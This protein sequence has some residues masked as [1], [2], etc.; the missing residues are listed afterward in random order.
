MQLKLENY[1]LT[2]QI[3]TLEQQLEKIALKKR[4]HSDQLKIKRK[5]L[6]TFQLQLAELEL[7]LRE[8]DDLLNDTQR[9][10]VATQYDSDSKD[11]ELLFMQSK[12]EKLSDPVTL[13][14][15]RDALVSTYKKRLGELEDYIQTL[16]S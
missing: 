12:L 8:R 15:E 13:K 4:S 6:E 2:Q 14:F 1:N 11:R 10:L 3:T 7:K 9:K 16:E 5:E